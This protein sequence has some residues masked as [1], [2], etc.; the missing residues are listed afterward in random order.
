MRFFFEFSTFF[1]FVLHCYWSVVVFSKLGKK[2]PLSSI[3]TDMWSH[4]ANKRKKRLNA[5]K[6][7]G[8]FCAW[9]W[10]ILFRNR[11]L[12]VSFYIF[13]LWTNCARGETKSKKKTGYKVKELYKKREYYVLFHI[14]FFSSL[15][16]LYCRCS[17]QIVIFYSFLFVILHHFHRGP[18]EK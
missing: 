11:F 3:Y 7:T 2:D 1:F 12:L 16:L 6:T 17:F 10:Y 8:N 15:W 14:L 5:V 4:N 9:C 18:F 13:F